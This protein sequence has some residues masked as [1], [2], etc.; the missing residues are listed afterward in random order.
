MKYKQPLEIFPELAFDNDV[1]YI[2]KSVTGFMDVGYDSCFDNCAI[3][4]QFERLLKLGQ[5]RNHAT[6]IIVD[7]AKIRRYS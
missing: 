4:A 1:N 6:E 3:L 7:N 5:F 2:E